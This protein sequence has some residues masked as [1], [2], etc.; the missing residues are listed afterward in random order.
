[1]NKEST[2]GTGIRPVPVLLLFAALFFLLVVPATAANFSQ[3]FLYSDIVHV[4]QTYMTDTS[5]TMPLLV[6]LAAIA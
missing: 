2:T 1:M 5:G 6:W 4:N 3:A